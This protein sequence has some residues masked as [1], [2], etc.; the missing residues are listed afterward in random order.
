[1]KNHLWDSP[2]YEEVMLPL[3]KKYWGD[4]LFRNQ[5]GSGH[6]NIEYLFMR[7]ADLFEPI[8]REGDLTNALIGFQSKEADPKVFFW[9][10]ECKSSDINQLTVEYSRYLLTFKSLSEDVDVVLYRSVSSRSGC[11]LACLGEHS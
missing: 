1:M 8:Y 2:Y 10:A 5:D 7:E 11:G 3:K 9:N 6:F 4:P